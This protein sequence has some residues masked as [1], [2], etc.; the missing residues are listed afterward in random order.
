MYVEMTPNTAQATTLQR[1][2]DFDEIL[3]RLDEMIARVSHLGDQT[4]GI[5]SRMFGP[6]PPHGDGATGPV[7][8]PNGAIAEA[9]AKIDGI[10]AMLSRIE[11]HV[12]RLASI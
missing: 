11:A 12:D 4:G 9:Q 6:M 3:T 2:R 5:V 1:R 7:P 10:G 8:V